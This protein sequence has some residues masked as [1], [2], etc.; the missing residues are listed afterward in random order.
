VLDGGGKVT[1][2]GAGRVRILYQNTCD[3]AQV[4]TS[5]QC[6]RQTSPQLTLQNIHFEQGNSIGQAYGL[7]RHVYGGGAVYVRGGQLKVVNSRFVG[8]QCE[9]VGPDVGGGAVRVFGANASI[10]NSTF[11]GNRCS[12]GGALSGLNASYS[13]YNSTFTGNQAVGRGQNP[14][15][16]NNPGGGS[17]GAIYNDGGFFNLQVCGSEMQENTAVEGGG[18][19]FY[20]SNDRSGLMSLTDSVFTRNPSGA[21][22][23]SG[24]PGMFVLAAPG[25]PVLRGSRLSP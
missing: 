5:A 18:A 10:V 1:L 15:V 12:N 3:E 6:D 7:D 20:V 25:Q 4:W 23:T 19:I 11:S 24:L 16:G 21:F 9:A 2:S 22:E 14:I 8:N 17:G 13:V